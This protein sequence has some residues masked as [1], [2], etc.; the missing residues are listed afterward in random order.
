[1]QFAWAACL[2]DRVGRR[3]N[4]GA[5]L[6]EEAVAGHLAARCPDAAPVQTRPADA[7]LECVDSGSE[8]YRESKSYSET[9]ISNNVL[10]VM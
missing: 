3:E 7:A 4:P 10:G 5:H 8:S 9:Y 6:D 1:M 2:A